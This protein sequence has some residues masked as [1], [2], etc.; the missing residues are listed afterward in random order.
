M[1]ELKIVITGSPGV[2]KTTAIKAISDTPPVTTEAGTSDALSEIK[3]TTTVAF[4]FGEVLLDDDVYLRVYGTPGQQRFKHMWDIIA[5]GAL[6]FIILIDVTRKNAV[7]DLDLYVKYF[8]PFIKKTSA[9]IALTRSDESDDL[10]CYYD[11]LEKNGYC[12]PVIDADPRSKSD[13][14]N[15]IMALISMLEYA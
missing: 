15:V 11:Y 9:V 8:A 13:M 7:D 14:T 6:G 3:D 4:D 10:E 1:P 12:F 2:G 5:E